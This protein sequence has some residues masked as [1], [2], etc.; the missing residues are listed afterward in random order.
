M[1]NTV[2]DLVT[3]GLRIAGITGVGQTP[4]AED[5]NDA[6]TVLNSILAEWQVNRWL[7]FDLVEAVAA[8]T[9]AVSYTVGIGGAFTLN[10]A[11]QRPDKV[12]A[13][14]ARLI[15]TGVDTP[16]YP[17]MS[18]EGYSRM[19]AKSLA[20]LPESY[21]YDAQSGATGTIYFYPPP[22]ALYELH[23]A[24]KASLGQYAHLTDVLGLPLQ[25]V[26]ALIWNLAANLRP[27]YALGDD[28][29][30]TA[31]AQGSLQSIINSVTQLAQAVQPQATRRGGIFSA[32]SAPPKGEG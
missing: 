7:V 30:V 28:P 19:P 24:A 18:R 29:S 9:A 21:F 32:M 2:G 27:L 31:R 20:G 12:D 3:F 10:F 14:F 23:V 13:A 15:S 11:G 6:L 8:S 25:Y 16:L 5:A 4:M 17:F 26:T 1:I 22:S